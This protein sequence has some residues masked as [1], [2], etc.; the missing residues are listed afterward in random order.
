MIKTGIIG[1]GFSSLSAACY[2]AKEGYE[3]HVFEQHDQA[4]GRARTF[5]AEG[6]VFDMGHSWYWMP[7]V[8][9]KFFNDFGKKTEDYYSLK[10]LDPSYNVYFNNSEV[11]IPANLEQLKNLFESWEPGSA[12]AL[13][14]FLE[15]A[16]FKYHLGMDN[17]VLKPG[18]S[19]TEFFDAEVLSG[20]LKMHVFKSF[21]AYTKKFFK[22]ERILKLLEFPILFLGATAQTTPALYSL[23]NYADIKLGTWYPMGGMH[24]IVEGMQS[25]AEELGVH[26]HFNTQVEQIHIVKGHIQG[27]A[28]K[29]KGIFALDAVVAGADYHFV[30]TKLLP[31]PYRQYSESYW[32]SRQMAPSALIFYLGIN[33]RIEGLHHHTLFFD[34]EFALHAEE[35]Y[36]HPKWPEKPLFYVCAPSVTDATVAPVGSEN[37]FILMPLAPGIEDTE[38]LREQYY[39]ILMERMEKR[40]GQSIAKHV[41]FKRSYAINDFVS[42]YNAF[43]GNA[44]GLA[45]TL[46]QTAIFKPSILNKK[47]S[48]LFYTGQLTVPG[49]GVPPAIISGKIAANELIKSHQL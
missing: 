43:K 3:V 33:K 8:F 48:G 39:S 32:G 22:D 42:D 6:F 13:D 19:I 44:Y 49:P 37:I 45:N 23:M 29:D 14:D 21:D 18:K 20:V 7:D 28:L 47:V 15:E 27:L 24:K 12:E 25:L 17:I 34:E 41:A 10:R 40:M 5:S 4:G 1:S 9:E 30:E 36:T 46:K 16:R 11:E 31:K 2:L 38:S 35:I 26:F